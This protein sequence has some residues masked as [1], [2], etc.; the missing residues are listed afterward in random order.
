MAWA[1]VVA[2]VGWAVWVAWE[3]NRHKRQPLPTCRTQFGIRLREKAPITRGFFLVRSRAMPVGVSAT[4]AL[5]PSGVSLEPSST[6]LLNTDR[7]PAKRARSLVALRAFFFT[8]N[9]SEGVCSQ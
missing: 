8:I 7:T 6:S 4:V 2:W 1:V 3:C 9:V 5:F